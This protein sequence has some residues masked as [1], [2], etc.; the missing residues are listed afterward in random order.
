MA[1]KLLI[2]ARWLLL[3]RTRAHER[4]P[5]EAIYRV[6]TPMVCGIPRA[7]E[8]KSRPVRFLTVRDQLQNARSRLEEDLY[9]PALPV[10]HPGKRFRLF[11]K[12]ALGK[13]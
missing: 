12:T 3:E 6:L 11:Q 5:P 7:T 1:R 10:R 2:I 13:R 9:R 8:R 4:S